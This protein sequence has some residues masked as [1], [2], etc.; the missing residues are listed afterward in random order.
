[1][2]VPFSVIAKKLKI[3]GPR[4]RRALRH[5][6]IKGLDPKADF[7]K[8][9]VAQE[10]IQALLPKKK[11]PIKVKKMEGEKKT[12]KDKEEVLLPSS[13]RVKDLAGL[14]KIPVTDLLKKL[15]KEGVSAN[16][17]QSLDFE[18]ASLIAEDFGKKVGL[19]EDEAKEEEEVVERGE[20]RP[21]IVVILG[22]VD[23]GKTSLLDYIRKTKVAQRESGG[24]TQHIGSYQAEID[25]EGERRQITFIDT[26]GHEAFS[27][28]RSLGAKVTD[29]AVLVVAADDG[30]KPQTVEAIDHAK[31]AGI[32]IVVA[33]NKIDK[34]GA[35]PEKVKKE[36]AENGLL[37]EEWGGTTPLVEIS[38][39]TGKNIDELL[40]LIVLTA[41]LSDIQARYEGMGEGVVIESHIERGKGSVASI[42]CRQGQFKKGDIVV[43]GG[44][45]GRIKRI[46]NERKE[47]K[48]KLLPS[49]PALVFGFKSLPRP[50]SKVRVVKGEKEAKDRAEAW[51]REMRERGFAQS[52]YSKVRGEKILPIVLKADVQ[53]SLE[54]LMSSLEK[55]K[56][57]KVKVKVV[58]SGVGNISESDIYLALASSALI[59]GFRVKSDLAAQRLAEQRQ[60]KILTFDVIYDLLNELEKILADISAPKEKEVKTGEAE[61]IKLFKGGKVQILGAQLKKSLIKVGDKVKIFRDNKAIG[62]G[63]VKSLKI[64]TKDKKEIKEIGAKFGLGLESKTTVKIGDRIVAFAIEKK[65]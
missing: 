57:D 65:I 2:A 60:V 55:L 27:K 36:L 29:L 13:V 6:E 51:E 61:V 16:L 38:A 28:L 9:E 1:M 8:K 45:W 56:S 40:E 33:V 15:L 10:I 47:V 14:L 22:H 17:N 24:I 11:A 44:A 26:P 30:V 18:T 5:L 34:K 52:L 48:E 59:L 50:G 4:L 23:H 19:L 3:E 43:A 25:S 41:D 54:S 46:E 32:P 53:G 12:K 20:P 31:S 58:H 39:K 21:P 7:F 35:D 37:P 63:E 42:I 62:M 49:E 64:L